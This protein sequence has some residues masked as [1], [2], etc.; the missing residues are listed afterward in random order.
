MARP[1]A[2][3]NSFVLATNPVSYLEAA[4]SRMVEALLGNSGVKSIGTPTM[5]R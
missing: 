5:P 2:R 3:T 4:V 1:P